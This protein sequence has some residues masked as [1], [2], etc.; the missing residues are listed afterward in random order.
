M[1]INEKT[2]PLTGVK[3]FPK[4][5]NQRFI[6]PDNRIKFNN[7]KANKFRHSL[8]YVNKPLNKNIRILNELM[9]NKRQATF[10]KQ[11]L[12][13]KGLN[14]GVHTHY[15][16]YEEKSQIAIYQFIILRV[17]NEQIKIIKND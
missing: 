11:F 13:G 8:S 4:R 3:F 1:K 16:T 12:I 2:D 5:I 17:D 9:Q 14:F 10:H 6:S 15:E 7:D